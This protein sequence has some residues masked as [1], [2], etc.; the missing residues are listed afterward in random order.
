MSSIPTI[1]WKPNG[2]SSIALKTLRYAY[3]CVILATGT[4][5]KRKGYKKKTFLF[6]K[7][8][9]KCLDCLLSLSVSRRGKTLKYTLSIFTW[10]YLRRPFYEM[11]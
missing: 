6:L 10:N 8:Y 5:G 4:E 2:F 9:T 1:S 3:D 11:V 7:C